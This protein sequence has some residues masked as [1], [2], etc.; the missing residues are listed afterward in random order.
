MFW[1]YCVLMVIL[2]WAFSRPV[3]RPVTETSYNTNTFFMETG[4]TTNDCGNVAALSLKEIAP[5]SHSK[6]KFTVLASMYTSAHSWPV[7]S[8]SYSVQ[9][10]CFWEVWIASDTLGCGWVVKTLDTGIMTLLVN[11]PLFGQQASPPSAPLVCGGHS[12]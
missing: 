3:P 1:S 2:Y 9:I 8:P 10:L 4:S 7:S 5:W 6:S 11:T 12:I